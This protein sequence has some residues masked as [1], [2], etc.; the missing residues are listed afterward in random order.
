MKN[1]CVLVWLV[2]PCRPV[3]SRVRDDPASAT[4]V[5][6]GSTGPDDSTTGSSTGSPGVAEQTGSTDATE[7]PALNVLELVRSKSGFL[8]ARMTFTGSA[9]T[10]E[11]PA[12]VD[13]GDPTPVSM[14]SSLTRR[15][16]VELAPTGETGDHA[17]GSSFDV[18]EGVVP[19]VDVG[20]EHLE[21]VPVTPGQG[22]LEFVSQAVDFPFD[23]AIGWSFVSR[24]HFRFDD[25]GRSGV[26]DAHFIAF[27]RE[28]SILV[29]TFEATSRHGL[30]FASCVTNGNHARGRGG[31]QQ[32]SVRRGPL[33]Q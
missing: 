22:E 11:V 1:A 5:G 19:D 14:S 7:P 25:H 6:E 26:L 13:F 32:G 21:E 15:I 2:V 29:R 16:G 8:F 33:D 10:E 23:A 18:F 28:S 24:Y 30:E 17:D 27:S 31:L 12:T 9:G 4:D 3:G 20:I